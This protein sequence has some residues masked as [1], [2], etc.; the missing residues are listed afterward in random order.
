MCFEG[1]LLPGHVSHTFLCSP[2]SSTA[3]TFDP[4]FSFVSTINLHRDCSPTLLHALADSHPN[5]DVWLASY[6]EEKEG[7]ESLNTFCRITLGVYCALREK[8]APCAIPMMCVLTIKKDTNS[9]PLWAKSRN[10]DLGNYKNHVW[11]KSDKFALVLHGNS[12]RCLV[13]L[14]V[15][16]HRPLR[17]G[18]CKN[19]FCQDILP[20]DEINIVCPPLSNPNADP[21][22]YWFLLRTIYG[23][24]WSPCHWYDK[25]KSILLSIGPCPSPDDPCFYSG[26]I[27][28]PSN[29]SCLPSQHPLCLGLYVDDFVY[30]SK[31][32]EVKSLFCCLLA[33][34]CKV[35]F[36]G[37]V[38]WFLDVHFLWYIAP[39]SVTVHL[40]QSKFALN[41]VEIFSR[42]NRRIKHLLQ[43]L[44]GQ[45]FL[46][47]RSHL[48]L[49]TR[50][51]LS[52][53][54]AR[55]PIRVSLVAL[56][57]LLTLLALTSILYIP[58]FQR[59]ATSL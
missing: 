19:A 57:G 36:I 49:K 46:L 32:P 22:E 52:S 29:P 42:Q 20:P 21:K 53:N 13:S 33:K 31:D 15:Q 43:L 54:N 25:I 39:S 48:R 59:T 8:R 11:S 5:C 1:T 23:L 27:Q 40:S 34:R 10:V 7:L 50:I 16:H 18:N 9:L 41:L 3:L 24:W 45:A 51:L 37:K 47:M 58:S 56:V 14:A 17:Q 12:L 4:A 26:F 55:M 38:S 6:K 2:V 35:D 28:D 30:F 44:M